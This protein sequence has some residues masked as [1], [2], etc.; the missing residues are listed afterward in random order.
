MVLI[1][2]LS[3]LDQRPHMDLENLALAQKSLRTTDLE[4]L[5]V[6]VDWALFQETTQQ[7]LVRINHSLSSS[8]SYNCI[9]QVLWKVKDKQ[10]LFQHIT[11]WVHFSN[12]KQVLFLHPR[13]VK[14]YFVV[15][16]HLVELVNEDHSL[17]WGQHSTNF[18]SWD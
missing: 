15:L 7:V 6:N 9:W 13:L 17:A 11:Q 1:K 4:E 18:S 8:Y 5:S 16:A 14:S 3:S 10:V 2:L 12:P